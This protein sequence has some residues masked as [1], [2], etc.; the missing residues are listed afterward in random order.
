MKFSALLALTLSGFQFEP[1]HTKTRKTLQATTRLII[2]TQDR[3]RSYKKRVRMKEDS[4]GILS[5]KGEYCPFLFF[6][7]TSLTTPLVMVATFVGNG[8]AMTT[9]MVYGDVNEPYVVRDIGC[10]LPIT[11]RRGLSSLIP[12]PNSNVSTTSTC[13]S[14]GLPQAVCQ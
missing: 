14:M 7:V 8:T 4:E 5:A 2:I 1:R 13:S 9:R 12:S 3:Q 11:R 10:A 6:L